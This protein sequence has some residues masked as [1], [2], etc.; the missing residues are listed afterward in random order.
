MATTLSLTT[1][2]RLTRD[3]ILNALQMFVIYIYFIA[4]VSFTLHF[5]HF[6]KRQRKSKGQ[7][8]IGNLEARATFA[9]RH[10]TKT[11]RQHNTEN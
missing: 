1:R 4:S 3:E 9:T 2:Y 6:N 10:R 11:K 8:R 5:H 7:P